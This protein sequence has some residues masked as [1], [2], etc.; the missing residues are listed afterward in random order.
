MTQTCRDRAISPVDTG[1]LGPGATQA[2]GIA[3]SSVLEG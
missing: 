2:A 1:V 3:E